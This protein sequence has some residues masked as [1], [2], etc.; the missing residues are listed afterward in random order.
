MKADVVTALM[1]DA[2]FAWAHAANRTLSQGIHPTAND[3]KP[4]GKT[5]ATHLHNL[6]FDGKCFLAYLLRDGFSR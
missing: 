3:M 6:D 2:A 5:V 1:Y 4:F